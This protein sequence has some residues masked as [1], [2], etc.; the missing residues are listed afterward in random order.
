MKIVNIST[1]KA[2]LLIIDMQNGLVDTEEIFPH[3]VWGGGVANH[4]IRP[5]RQIVSNIKKL[6]SFIKE[7]TNIPIYYSKSI[8]KVS[9]ID[10]SNIIPES[11][12]AW[13][14]HPYF[15][16]SWESEIIPELKPAENDYMIE[17]EKDS[18]FHNT[19]FDLCLNFDQ[20]DTIIFAGIDTYICVEHTIR[21]AFNMG[22]NVIAIEDCLASR[23]SAF[24]KN[25]LKVIE[26]TF[27]L[28]IDLNKFMLIMS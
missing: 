28:V 12:K 9:D 27:G 13:I 11:R 10:E 7:N 8:G 23:N 2:V 22:Y 16:G 4:I 21:D 6:I 18:V 1:T 19:K 15:Q 26:E 5:Y 17:K 14:A 25:S 20:A 3:M 24:H